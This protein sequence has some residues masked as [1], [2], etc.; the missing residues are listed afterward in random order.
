MSFKKR[1]I[2]SD[3]TNK[4]L[5]EEIM[6]DII[7]IYEYIIQNNTNFI[8]GNISSNNGKIFI[9]YSD[10]VIKEY[11]ISGSNYSLYKY[12]KIMLI[13]NIVHYTIIIF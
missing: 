2:V 7:N 4:L 6:D 9:R 5:T 1:L 11:L 8:V 3:Y 12:K 13:D 10:K